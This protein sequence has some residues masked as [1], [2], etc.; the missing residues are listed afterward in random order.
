MTNIPD[1]I[2]AAADVAYRAGTHEAIVTALM[3]FVP[4]DMCRH[5]GQAIGAAPCNHCIRFDHAEIG[6]PEL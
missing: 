5:Q 6:D 3:G 4:C 1:R 2:R